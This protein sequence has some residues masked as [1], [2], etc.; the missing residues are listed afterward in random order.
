MRGDESSSAVRP[1]HDLSILYM[2]AD[3]MDD[4]MAEKL[5]A[6]LLEGGSGSVTAP[7]MD[8]D[9]DEGTA[10]LAARAEEQVTA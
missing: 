7:G 8:T 9:M 4:A 5:L 10:A 6:E 3:R 1:S 2:R